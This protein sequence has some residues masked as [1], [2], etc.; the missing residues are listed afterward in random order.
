VAPTRRVRLPEGVQLSPAQIELFDAA[1]QEGLGQFAY[2]NKLTRASLAHFGERAAISESAFSFDGYD[3]DGS[4]VIF[5]YSL[6]DARYTEKI[7]FAKLRAGDL[8]PEIISMQSGGKDSLLLA[9]M[10]KEQEVSFAPWFLRSGDHHPKVLDKLD[11]LLLATRTIDREGLTKAAEAGGKNGHIPITYVIQSLAL[12]QAMLL[13]AKTVVVA[14]GDE[15]TEPH[16]TISETTYGFLGG[17]SA[18]ADPDGA[19]VPALS[20]NSRPLV[21]NHQ[22]SKTR[23]AEAIYAKYLTSELGGDYKVYS[24]LRNTSELKIAELFARKCWKEFG[25]EFSSCNVANYRQHADN[26]ELKWC[27]DCP[28]CANAFLLFAPY[29]PSAELT[30]LFDG[31]DLFAKESLEHTFKGLLGIDGVEKPFECV[32]SVEELRTAYHLSHPV[33]VSDT[34]ESDYAALP[35]EIPAASA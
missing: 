25:H 15:G 12:V 4:T 11:H 23:E 17:A 29:L 33:G 9:T 26:R 30:P 31:Q 28:K 10:L 24:P 8:K 14:I 27:G 5:R 21:V 20:P 7:E 16:S 2:E 18:K 13:G 1:Y 6:G 34:D 22:W 3:F 35:F 32:G 19:S